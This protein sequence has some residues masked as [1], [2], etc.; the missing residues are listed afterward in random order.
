MLFQIVYFLLDLAAGLLAGTCLLRA[1]M[2]WQRIS[3]GNPVGRF[4]FAAT[5]WIVL[6]LRKLVPAIGRLDTASV[7]TAYL[8]QLA[9][10]GIL[11][12]FVGGAD[13]AILLPAVALFA[14]VQLAI[15]AVIGL[16]IVYA[17][18]SWVHADSPIVDV[19]DR[20]CAPMLRPLRKLIPLV[21][22]VDLSPLALMALLYVASIVLW[23]LAGLLGPARMLIAR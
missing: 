8:L 4:I 5:D 12:L 3:F 2:Q 11:W 14:L 6:P 1:F 9:R 19:I 17:I 18:L 13:V 22:G 10:F 21:G 23:N 16:L 15:S 7:L 20:V